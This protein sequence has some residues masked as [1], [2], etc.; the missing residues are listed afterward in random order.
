[1]RAVVEH[2]DQLPVGWQP[3][4]GGP[5][6]ATWRADPS[7]EKQISYALSLLERT[8]REDEYE[9]ED[10][11]AMSKGEISELIDELKAETR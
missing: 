7:T 6:R 10:L 1:M 8:G 11:E 9:F 2:G 4:V 3:G 5:S